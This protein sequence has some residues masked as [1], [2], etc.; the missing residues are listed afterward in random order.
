MIGA[1]VGGGAFLLFN[2][3]HQA[4]SQRR[5]RRALSRDI[6]RL[7]AEQVDLISLAKGKRRGRGFAERKGHR[8][9]SKRCQ[10]R[11]AVPRNDEGY[12]KLSRD[13]H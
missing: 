2:Q 5:T 6:Q 1:I 11:E 4:V 13:R 7:Q 9:G 12:D 8:V 10:L 3:L